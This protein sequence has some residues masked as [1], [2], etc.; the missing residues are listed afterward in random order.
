MNILNL[1][2]ILLLMLITTNFLMAGVNKEKAREEFYKASKSEEY[3]ESALKK[4]KILVKEDL[5]NTYRWKVYE[6]SLTSMKAMYVFWPQKKLKFANE[7]IEMMEKNIKKCSN[8]LEA[9]FVYGTSCHYMP[10]FMK[11]SENAKWAFNQMVKVIK[12]TNPDM[13]SELMKNVV[14]F[15]KEE[16]GINV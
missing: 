14:K 7:G 1:K 16:A 10:F 2:R 4:F 12:E 13:N 5:E 11:Q 8:D 9:L 3:L 6:G 15:L